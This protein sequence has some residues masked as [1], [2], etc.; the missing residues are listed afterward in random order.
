[1]LAAQHFNLNR[2][3]LIRLARRGVPSIFGGDEE[4]RRFDGLLNDF[5]R[6]Q[7]RTQS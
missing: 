1:M 5:E 6:D 2:K 7:A 3:D 4:K